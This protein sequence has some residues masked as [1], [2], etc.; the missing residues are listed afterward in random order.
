MSEEVMFAEAIDAV[1]KGQRSRAR[2]LLTRL[3]RNEQENPTYWLWMSSVVESKK[4]KIYCLENTLRLDPTNVMA[5]RGLVLFGS[6]PASENVTP[7]PIINRKWSVEKL[8]DTRS[9]EGKGDGLKSKL[10]NPT[11][12]IVL[13][14]L[15]GIIVFG[16][17]FVGVFGLGSNNRGMFA[18][19]QLTVTPKPWTPKP[20]ATLLP[21][22]TPRVKTPTPTFIGPTPLW[23]LLE[24]TYTPTPLYV[25]TPHPISEAYRAG[26]RAYHSGEVEEMLQ[27]MEQAA[28][29]EPESADTHYYIGEAHRVLENFE[30]AL[31]AYETAISVNE[32][33]AP[34]YLGR[35]RIYLQI[36]PDLG[37]EDDLIEAISLDPN[38]IEAYLALADYY[39]H[40]NDPE[41]ALDT[42]EYFDDLEIESPYIPLYKAQ[43]HLLLDEPNTAL[44]FAQQALALDQTLLPA[45][46][47]LGQI[48]LN[49]GFPRRAIDYLETYTNYITENAKA[50]ALLGES[51]Y[52]TNQA[53]EA[54]KA[55]DYSIEI[56]ESNYQVHLIRGYIYLDEGEGQLAVNEFFNARSLDPDSFEAC[57]G[58]AH[59]LLLAGRQGD[60]LRQ[61]NSCQTLVIDDKQQVSIFYHRAIIFEAIG[62]YKLAAEDWLALLAYP[63]EIVS[64]TWKNTAEKHLEDLTPT[65]SPT[66]TP[67]PVPITQTPNN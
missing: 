61:I 21:T 4:E 47:T 48:Y 27:F 50:W 62:N 36:N 6:Q 25:D 9:K 41:A 26:L 8:K 29:I 13:Y 30:L 10:A 56:E 7:T 51:Y 44:E 40:L 52:E 1:S 24:A 2:D 42:L 54:M 32:S 28:A 16:M 55:L 22:N 12:R 31:A 39:L 38:L 33:F 53:V 57:V 20:T 63:T 15:A 58:M 67:T 59:A 65:P 19:V 37:V 60:T 43:A 18:D 45:Y 11:L 34:A 14:S 3:L 17:I 64:R 66:S 23:M 5:Q 49:I 46:L 35:A